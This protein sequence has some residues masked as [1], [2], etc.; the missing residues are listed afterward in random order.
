MSPRGSKKKIVLGMQK[1]NL[2]IEKAI[3]R[4]LYQKYDVDLPTDIINLVNFG[5]MRH[6]SHPSFGYVPE[7]IKL[8]SM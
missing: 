6:R 7:R 4:V 8:M 3:S 1:R 5:M 2:P